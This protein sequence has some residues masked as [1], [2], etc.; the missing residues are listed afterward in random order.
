MKILERI[1]YVI[2]QQA[3]LR[4]R[5]TTQGGREIL[6]KVLNFKMSPIPPT[7]SIR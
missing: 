4:D 2:S 6:P 7:L 1:L 5:E 3:F